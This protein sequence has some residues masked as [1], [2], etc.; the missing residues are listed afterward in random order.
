MPQ[1][2]DTEDWWIRLSETPDGPNPWLT[3]DQKL[4][5]RDSK[6]DFLEKLSAN[7]LVFE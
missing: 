2:I 5:S 3:Y 7:T 4:V 6:N 1:C